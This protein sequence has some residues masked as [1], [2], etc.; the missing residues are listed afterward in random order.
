MP[1]AKSATG[2]VTITALKVKGQHSFK[3]VV[4][5]QI[6]D[7]QEAQPSKY[8]QSCRSQVQQHIVL[9]SRQVFKSPSISTNPEL[10]NA[11]TEW[12]RLMPTALNGRIIP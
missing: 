8:N 7:D 12:N 2:A 11:A 4:L 5:Y 1:D 10:L 3:G 9:I 6:H